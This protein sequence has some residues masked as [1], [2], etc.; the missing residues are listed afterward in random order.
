MAS[1]PAFAVTPNVGKGK[2]TTGN[3]AKDGT[4]TDIITLFTAGSSG[5]KIDE[6]VV[7]ADGDPADS[8]VTFFLHD[9]SAYYTFDDWDIGNPAAGST[10]AGAYRQN[11]TYENLV[12]PASWTVR[13]LVSVTPT[14][15]SI[16]VT[17]FGADF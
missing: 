3:S 17:V 10:T 1:A 12:L 8:C 4:G 5:S 2:L 9:G 7:Q 11:R 13:A 16:H 14:A 15:G 6:I